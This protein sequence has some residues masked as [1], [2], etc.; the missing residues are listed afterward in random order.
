[1]RSKRLFL[2]AHA[3]LAGAYATDLA[4]ETAL[5]VSEKATA[6]EFEVLEQ[7]KIQAGDH[8]IILNRVAPPILPVAPTAVAVAVEPVEPKI[9]PLLQRNVFVLLS[10]TV[11]DR[12]VTELRWFEEGKTYHVYSNIDFN[13]IT[14]IGQFETDDTA[15]LLI[16]GIGNETRAAVAEAEKNAAAQGYVRDTLKS[17]P[18]IGQFP[19]DYSA[20]FVAEDSADEDG[21]AFAALDALHA[22]Y[23]ANR[24]QLQKAYQ[25]REATRIEQERWLKAH[26]PV[27]QNTVINFW[28]A[29]NTVILDRQSKIGKP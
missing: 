13:Y 5:V 29:E 26:P 16:L 23:D 7:T 28:P 21:K 2:I 10:A 22:Y 15:Y 17:L 12:E 18:D 3:C 19:Q 11:Y 9:Q 4:N 24:D 1:M 25:E 8:A 27:P 6:I 14:G 20:Y